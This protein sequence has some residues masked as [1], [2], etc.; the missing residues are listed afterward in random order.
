MTID[1][2]KAGVRFAPG[3]NGRRNCMWAAENVMVLLCHVAIL[4][5]SEVE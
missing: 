5:D 4:K 1:L 2:Y 3:D